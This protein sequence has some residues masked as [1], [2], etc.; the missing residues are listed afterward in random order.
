MLTEAMLKA[1]KKKVAIWFNNIPTKQIEEVDSLSPKD[2]QGGLASS[3]EACSIDHSRF[4][5][6]EDS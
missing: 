3:R 6:S 2:Y 4:R 5:F 1:T